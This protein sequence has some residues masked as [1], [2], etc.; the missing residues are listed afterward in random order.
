MISDEATLMLVIV[1]LYL[2]DSTLMLAANEAVLVR[3]RK[4]RWFA[5]FGS[6]NYR[7]AGKEPY[8]PNPLTPHRPLFALAWSTEA[9]PVSAADSSVARLDA[10][11]SLDAMAVFVFPMAL[12]LFVLLPLGLFSRLGIIFTYAAIALFY[13]NAVAALAM[14]YLRRQ[15][16]KI[17]SRQLAAIA[18]QCVACPPFALNLVRKLCAANPMKIDLTVAAAQLLRPEEIEQVN[19]QCLLRLDEQIDFEPDGSSRISTMTEARA[20]FLP[21]EEVS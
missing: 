12:A 7:L 19:A 10:E 1:A 4:G 3:A 16:L 15:E 6:Q 5:S 2:Y 14:V 13:A 8:L 9:K 17:T 18:F 20:R 21:R 11:T